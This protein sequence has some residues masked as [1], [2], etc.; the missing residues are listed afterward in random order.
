MMM[1]FLLNYLCWNLLMK[2][3]SQRIYQKSLKWESKGANR[4][5]S[6]GIS[7]VVLKHWKIFLENLFQKIRTMNNF[8]A[9]LLTFLYWL[10]LPLYS[11]EKGSLTSLSWFYFKYCA[12]LVLPGKRK[13][14][15]HS[16]C[17]HIGN[18]RY[19]A[20]QMPSNALLWDIYTFPCWF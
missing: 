2:W 14:L 16:K 18:W 4:A 20:Y 1:S 6:T 8:F 5:S 9:N 7:H 15:E 17:S 3:L 12:F 19:C 13:R 10:S 11:T